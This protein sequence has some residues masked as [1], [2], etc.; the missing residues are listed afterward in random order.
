MWCCVS[1][2]STKPFFI[3]PKKKSIDEGEE[4]N[5]IER[6][7]WWWFRATDWNP[8]LHYDNSIVIIYSIQGIIIQCIRLAELEL[9]Q[10]IKVTREQ[11]CWECSAS[12][13][14]HRKLPNI[15]S[16]IYIIFEYSESLEN[17]YNWLMGLGGKIKK[18]EK[19]STFFFIPEHDDVAKETSG[20]G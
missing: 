12:W 1:R 14:V 4:R 17:V 10:R 11:L 5:E 7:L 15:Y 8:N 2:I 3:L 16:L 20:G 13:Y 18:E 6:K 19:S 9:Q